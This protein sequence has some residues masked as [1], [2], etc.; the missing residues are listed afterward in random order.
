M[1][2]IENNIDDKSNF[3]YYKQ[4]CTYQHCSS[5]AVNF[6]KFIIFAQ[7]TALENELFKLKIDNKVAQKFVL[8][9]PKVCRQTV[10]DT[11]K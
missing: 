11:R 7:L 5:K 10:L 9:T 6:I 8:K 3:D 1:D 2:Y 4:Y